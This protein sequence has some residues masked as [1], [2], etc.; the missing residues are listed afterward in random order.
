VGPRKNETDSTNSKSILITKMLK[1]LRCLRLVDF[2][3][4]LSVGEPPEKGGFCLCHYWNVCTP[5]RHA[6]LWWC[7]LRRGPVPASLVHQPDTLAS[8]GS[9]SV[10]H[11]PL[12]TDRAPEA[13]CQILTAG[14]PA[15]NCRPPS[16]GVSRTACLLQKVAAL[17]GST[18]AG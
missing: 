4:I 17:S 3:C 1:K 10:H 7:D 15:E 5:R 18:V 16:F 9:V 6:G 12:D 8:G 11:C 14:S 2:E 13:V